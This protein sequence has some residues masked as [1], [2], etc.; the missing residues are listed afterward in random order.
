MHK[1]NLVTEE[2]IN[3]WCP[4]CKEELIHGGDHSY[5]DCE[6][7]EEDGIVSN[8]ECQNEDCVVETVVICMPYKTNE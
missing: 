5:E 2:G 8:F 6:I 4:N 3:M 7:H 1:S